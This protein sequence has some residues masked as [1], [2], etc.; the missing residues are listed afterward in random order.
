M[1]GVP[2]YLADGTFAGYVGAALDIQDRKEA[3]QS[4][5]ELAGRLLRAQEDERARIARELHD[6]IAQRLALL[7]LRL[8][9]LEQE[10]SRSADGERIAD[11]RRQ[12]K[13]L[14]MDVSHL[15]HLLHSSYLEN[16]GLAA[17]VENQCREAGKLHHLDI[18]CKVRNLPRVLDH[19][20]A[21]SLFRVLQEALRNIIRHSHAGKVQVELFA[22]AAVIRLRVSDDGVGF[23]P[24]AP[25]SSEGLGLVSMRERLR[26]VG[27]SLDITSRPS[28][29]TRVEARAPLAQHARPAPAYADD[30]LLEKAG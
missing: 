6:D 21:L 19:D 14:S 23:D 27:G 13:Q 11:L 7:T 30:D 29:G 3:E 17:A 1:C 20:V 25:G 22:E 8:R 15:S 5:Q 28:R 9:Q 18:G 24:A 12:A 2:R 16:L 26:L 10:A 4:R